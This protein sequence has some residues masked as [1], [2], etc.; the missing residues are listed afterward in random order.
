FGGFPDPFDAFDDF[1][2][3]D[4]RRRAATGPGD[5]FLR[6]VVDKAEPWLGEQVT[7]SLYLFSQADISGVQSISF[8]KLDGFWAEDV[9]SPTQLTPEIREVKGVPYRAY[10]LRRRALFPLRA[11]ELVVDPV[12][13]QINL[14]MAGFFGGGRESVR[15]KS[16]PV[17]L[18]VKGLPA[19]GQPPGFEAANVGDLK[20]TVTAKPAQAQLGQPV[21][22]TAQ[23]EGSGNLKGVQLRL[24]RLPA[25]L[26]TYDPTVTDKPKISS[27]RY[28]GVKM[29]E[30]V[31][32][33]ERTGRFELPPVELPYFHPGRGNYDVLRSDAVSLD[34]SGPASASPAPSATPSTD[35]VPVPANVL[36]GGLR[37]LRLNP[38]LEA[39]PTPVWERPWF[40]PAT[41][42]PPMA[43]AVVSIAGAI[44]AMRRRRDPMVI[45]EQRARGEAARRLKAARALLSSS[46]QGA[47]QAEL[48]RSMQQF[49]TD[50]TGLSALGLTH[51]VLAAGLREQGLSNADAE[52]F[53]RLVETCEFARYASGE[54]SPAASENLLAEATRLIG[55]IDGLA[56]GRRS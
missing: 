46:E 36:S 8:P 37:A 52:A 53:A 54:S 32:L 49:V 34:V 1:D 12:E 25:G 21:Q 24:S 5:L 7:L 3:P 22:L 51:E 55:V 6:A 10:L 31:V 20:L 38:S 29:V 17:K 13:A 43:W 9:E 18:Q 2:F 42:A 41:A 56:K 47:F 48:L 35:A 11:G 26:K 50:R 44:G 15:R 33:P 27:G 4:Q 30:W 40:W 23:L 28:G 19:E 45:R 14:G 16:T 39:A